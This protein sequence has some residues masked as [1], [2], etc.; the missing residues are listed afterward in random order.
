MPSQN[1]GKDSALDHLR[2]RYV[3]F[4][5]PTP[6]AWHGML[7]GVDEHGVVE[8]QQLM[9]F[10][11]VAEPRTRIDAYPMYLLLRDILQRQLN[12]VL[13]IQHQ[14]AQA[15]RVEN[16]QLKQ[17]LDSQTDHIAD[18]EQQL[19]KSGEDLRKAEIVRKAKEE[20]EAAL[21]RAEDTL[22]ELRTNKFSLAAYR[23]K[24]RKLEA[25][26]Q[27]IEHDH[28]HEHEHA[29]WNFVDLSTMLAEALE[30]RG[31]DD[32]TLDQAFLLLGEENSKKLH[33][34]LKRTHPMLVKDKVKY[35]FLFSGSPIADAQRSEEL[36][37]RLHEGAVNS[38]EKEAEILRHL[39][40][41]E[42][43]ELLQRE[44]EDLRLKLRTGDVSA[45]EQA[46]AHERLHQVENFQRD[47]MRKET[48][49]KLATG[50]I[51]EEDAHLA[52]QSL[53]DADFA[54]QQQAELVRKLTSG[55]LAGEEIARVQ[56]ELEH[57][58][59][60]THLATTSLGEEEFGENGFESVEK[61]AQE[62][63][64]KADHL[65]RR[66]ME[67]NL[68]AAQ[69]KKLSAELDDVERAA[70]E[71]FQAT[72]K[73]DSKAEAGEMV[74]RAREIEEQLQS[75]ALS[76]E[77]RQRLQAEAGIVQTAT[78]GSARRTEQVRAVWK[79][80]MH[81][82]MVQ[83]RIMKSVLGKYS[84]GVI[85]H[86]MLKKTM[87]E[88]AGVLSA[89]ESSVQNAVDLRTVS[90]AQLTTDQ[91]K[92][93]VVS[94]GLYSSDDLSKMAPTELRMT[95]HEHAEKRKVKTVE[96][97]M[98]TEEK[99]LGV[100]KVEECLSKHVAWDPGVQKRT[101]KRYKA[102]K[103]TVASDGHT[104]H[105]KED[106][107][108]RAKSYHSTAL[109]NVEA[110]SHARPDKLAD[111]RDRS[112][113]LIQ[114]KIKHDKKMDTAMMRRDCMPDFVQQDFIQRYGLETIAAKHVH[115]FAA[116][117]FANEKQKE[118]DR[119]VKL[120][121]RLAGI[122]KPERYSSVEVNFVMDLL[123]LL[124]SSKSALALLPDALM[125]NAFVDC[126]LVRQKVH[127]LLTA[128][129]ETWHPD[130]MKSLEEN[131]CCGELN[132]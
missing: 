117:V 122:L 40:H 6:T 29:E 30:Q 127:L 58:E 42:E 11:A 48:A 51:S 132:H 54:A 90:N 68:T 80:N 66:L 21:Q 98:Q 49:A 76:D 114:L 103:A 18:L 95:M 119:L 111:T 118:P 39:A 4:M 105:E 79:R 131:I 96:T 38:A 82:I 35:K 43:T 71:V 130:L 9:N 86:E 87:K 100:R 78:D 37:T 26:V 113:K 65:R 23:N 70:E 97:E 3:D 91:Q 116:G 81:D 31:P 85:D 69:R 107:M 121:G 64:Q 72:M 46:Q 20:A 10:F 1:P 2:Y 61:G 32:Q 57:I 22:A 13:N 33:L 19:S 128:Y 74:N 15:L 59:H 123:D 101:K 120:M 16:S 124:F 14:E 77:K 75:P 45:E 63:V 108:L 106:P 7:D 36:Q 34:R 112:A 67:P 62:M 55:E 28:E 99:L 92:A 5:C 104:H 115:S 47:K 110:I 12:G 126:D 24:M 88:K 93:E 17:Q 44:E 50:E 56:A 84:R 89:I 109:T 73:I 102:K 125:Q 52:L 8:C 60:E 53:D 94:S 27:Q 25:K 83:V 129:V 41:L